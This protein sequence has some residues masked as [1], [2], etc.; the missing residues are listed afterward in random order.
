MQQPTQKHS[1]VTFILYFFFSFLLNFCCCCC[2]AF[3]GWQPRPMEV[4]RLGVELEQEVLAYTTAIRDPNRVCN[5]YHSSRQCQILNPLSEARDRTPI[6]MDTSQI[7]FCCATKGT[8]QKNIFQSL[9]SDT[10]KKDTA[11]SMSEPAGD[12]RKPTPT[13]RREGPLLKA[14]PSALPLGF[15]KKA[16]SR[17]CLGSQA[18][19]STGSSLIVLPLLP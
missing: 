16:P 9:Y 11:S 5:P 7:C 12:C 4:L 13:A 8:P 2:F 15:Q 3:L 19:P 17:H 14:G 10:K 18:P 1:E 6:L